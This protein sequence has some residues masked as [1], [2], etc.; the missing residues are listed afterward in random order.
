[1]LSFYQ[2][3]SLK[4]LVGPHLA[5]RGRMVAEQLQSMLYTQNPL[6]IDWFT[7]EMKMVL[8]LGLCLKFCK[9]CIRSPCEVG[10]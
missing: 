8:I 6:Q 7:L 10:P 1:M 9:I 4:T 2:G 3:Q 5:T